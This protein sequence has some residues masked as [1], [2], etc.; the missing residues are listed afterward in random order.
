MGCGAIAAR[1]GASIR[2]KLL[3][4]TP[5]RQRGR[6]GP[7]GN[8]TNCA[9]PRR[10]HRHRHQLSTVKRALAGTSTGS[11][12]KKKKNHRCNAGKNHSTLRG[13]KCLILSAG[14]ADSSAVTLAL[15]GVAFYRPRPYAT[16]IFSISISTSI[17]ISMHQ[18]YLYYV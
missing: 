10:R 9:P 6:G 8:T 15:Y 3:G 13:T 5:K 4:S 17:S 11:A 1:V 16:S 2:A 18:P 7:T 12:Q 14:V